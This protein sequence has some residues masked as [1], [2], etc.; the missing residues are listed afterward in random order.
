MTKEQSDLLSLLSQKLFN[1][2]TSLSITD[3]IKAEAQAQAV[4][5]LIAS[6]Y[7]T[8]GKNIRVINAHADLTEVFDD[9][10]FTSFKGYASAC[11][12]PQPIYRPMGDV[13]FIVS[14]ENYDPAVEKL[15][16]AG[17]TR[18][19]SEHERHEVFRKD[20]VTFELHS[21][22][23]G[24][25]NGADGIITDSATAEEKVRALLSD[26]IQTVR[27]VETQQ[28]KIVI[29]D[30]F[31]HGLI[32]L[33]HVAGHMIND[34][35][36]GLRH[37]CDWAV[38]VNRVDVEQFR[39]QLEDIGLWTFACQLTAVCSRYLGLP[40]Q[41]WAGMWDDQF[42]SSF[43]E[44][45]LSAG[46]FGKK[47]AGRRVALV[48]EKS[49]FAELTKKRYPQAKGI[50][51]PTFMVANMLRY[52]WLMARGKRKVIKPSTFTGAKG[53]NELYKQFRL[54]EV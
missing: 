27:T 40:E 49:S 31:H 25:P 9:I 13:D 52:G 47:E 20:K 15:I 3:S 17:Y 28:G 1:K 51:L 11:Y 35:G 7:K 44:D 5:T 16:N 53:R 37:L 12:Y 23:K 19:G 18:T 36:V 38:Y 26:L 50:L 34:G 39:S 30:D 46:N 32:M 10:P 8:L 41:S 29:P 48:L 14:P 2:P 4:S 43:I 24:I 33:L 42:L 45:V 54:F 6:D 22:I 21:E